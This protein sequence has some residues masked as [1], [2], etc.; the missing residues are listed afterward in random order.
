MQAFIEPCLLIDCCYKAIVYK[1]WALALIES[2]VFTWLN[3]AA[4]ISPVTKIDAA[5]IQGR[6]LLEGGVYCTKH[7]YMRLLLK[8][9][10]V[11]GL[12]CHNVYTLKC[13]C[14][15]DLRITRYSN[16]SRGIYSRAAFMLTV[17]AFIAATI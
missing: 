16:N 10:E 13:R 15:Q 9:E 12:L 11:P 2:T 8:F 4:I 17:V 5:T 14:T 6:L 3:A 7:Y 1:T